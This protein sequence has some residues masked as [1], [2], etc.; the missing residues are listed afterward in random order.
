VKKFLGGG[1]TMSKIVIEGGKKLFG[2]TLA[3]GSKNAALPIIAASVLCP[4]ECEL[5][6]CPDLS[7]VGAALDIIRHLGISVP[8][9]AESWWNTIGLTDYDPDRT[10]TRLEAAVTINAA[11]DPFNMYDV[12]YDGNILR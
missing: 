3:Q 11:I 1:V 5:L 9:P 7:D 10:I 4:S 6:N 8:D 2:S 12:G